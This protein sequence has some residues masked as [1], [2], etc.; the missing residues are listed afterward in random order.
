PRSGWK[1]SAT[2]TGAGAVARPDS[3]PP[4]APGCHLLLRPALPRCSA[5]YAAA[6]T[7]GEFSPPVLTSQSRAVSDRFADLLGWHASCRWGEGGVE[8]SLGDRRLAK[9]SVQPEREN[10]AMASMGHELCDPAAER[11]P[12]GA[13]PIDRPSAPAVRSPARRLPGAGDY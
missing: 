1:A 5:F 7:G 12:C 3:A 13:W 8:R 2:R 9:E 10:G 4:P 11:L 6:H